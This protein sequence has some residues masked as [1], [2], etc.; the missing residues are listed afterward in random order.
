MS[1]QGRDCTI[2]LKTQ[3]REM[4]LPYAE[5]TIR[6][7]VSLLRENPAIEGDGNCGAIRR[8]VGVTGCVI[9]PLSIETIPLLFVLALG[10]SGVPVFVSE[11]QGLYRHTVNLSSMEQGLRFDLIQERGAVRTLYE[12][13]R[14]KGFELRIMR[15]AAIKLKIDIAGDKNPVTYS[16]PD[17][18]VICGG[19]RFR[20]DGVRYRINGKEYSNIYGLTI[21]TRKP[22][23]TQTE[24]WIHRILES[25]GEL[26]Q[27]IENLEI[28][29]QLYRDSY[30]YRSYGMFRLRL[31][32]L[33]LMADETDINSGDTVIGRLR[34]YCAGLFTADVFTSDEEVIE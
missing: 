31:S 34:F 7:A 11:T 21:A 1:V 13:C 26:P 22:G 29:A 23:G 8:S 10:R 5:E 19:E 32:R 25:T 15:G 27:L 3:Y 2:T 9:T 14:V 33:V 4:G 18:L 6:E 12:G 30:E 20:E 24:V 16:Y 28:T 17:R